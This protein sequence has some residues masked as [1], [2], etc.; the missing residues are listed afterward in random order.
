MPEMFRY[1]IFKCRFLTNANVKIVSFPNELPCMFR[2][3]ST[4]VTEIQQVGKYKI[5]YLQ[6]I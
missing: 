2:I 4:F 3:S 5:T 1:Q 6:L